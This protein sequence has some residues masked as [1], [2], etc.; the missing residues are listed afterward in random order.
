M[1]FIYFIVTSVVLSIHLTG[2][3]PYDS[4]AFDF[5]SGNAEEIVALA[6]SKVL[7]NIEGKEGVYSQ[8]QASLVLKDFFSKNPCTSFEFVFKGERSADGAFAIGN[9]VSTRKFRVTIYFKKVNGVFK[10]ESLTIEK[11]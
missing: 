4:I 1:Q 6:K 3:I 9:Y 7:V 2:D 8:P 10:I 5:K 11:D